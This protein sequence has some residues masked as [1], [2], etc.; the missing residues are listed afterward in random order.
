MAPCSGRGPRRYR[1]SVP[2]SVLQISDEADMGNQ[3]IGSKRKCGKDQKNEVWI[4]CCSGTRRTASRVLRRLL[5]FTSAITGDQCRVAIGVLQPSCGSRQAAC[6]EAVFEKAFRGYR[7]A[8]E[9][10]G[11]TLSLCMTL[12]G[13]LPMRK[14]R[15]QDE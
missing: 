8:A 4:L 14:L 2:G 11:V 6:R 3:V 15:L 10:S 9:C 1:G 7:H 13:I 5:S 12:S